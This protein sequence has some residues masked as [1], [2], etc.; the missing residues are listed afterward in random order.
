MGGEGAAPQGQPWPGEAY[1]AP[2]KG[3]SQG[4]LTLARMR[5]SGLLGALPGEAAAVRWGGRVVRVD[6]PVAG[7]VLVT[8]NVYAPAQ[9]GDRPAFFAQLFFFFFKGG[10]RYTGLACAK[11]TDPGSGRTAAEEAR[12]HP[13]ARRS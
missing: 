2:G 12:P 11:A 4:C 8:V 5:P 10:T 13:A 1:A 7:R 9:G 6:L 3:H